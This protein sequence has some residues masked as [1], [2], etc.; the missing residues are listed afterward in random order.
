MHEFSFGAQNILEK[1]KYTKSKMG[2]SKSDNKINAQEED[3]EE[4]WSPRDKWWA[5]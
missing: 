5:Q 2:K 3:E 1:P 4:E